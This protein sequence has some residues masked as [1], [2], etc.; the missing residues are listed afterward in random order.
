[1]L[2]RQQTSTVRLLCAV[3]VEYISNEN[4]DAAWVAGIASSCPLSAK[5]TN[6]QAVL[7]TI[8]QSEKFLGIVNDFE[9]KTVP[10]YNDDACCYA[11]RS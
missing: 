9:M 4:R 2:P 11:S 1:M 5:Q 3:R 7:L 10:A 8:T 6:E